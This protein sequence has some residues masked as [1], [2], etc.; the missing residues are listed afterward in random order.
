L[1]EYDLGGRGPADVA[2][3][4]E[5]DLARLARAGHDGVFC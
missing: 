2:K 5:Q 4:H 1:P 3:A